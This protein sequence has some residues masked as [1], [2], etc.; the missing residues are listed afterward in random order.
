MRGTPSWCAVTKGNLSIDLFAAR[1]LGKW[2]NIESQAL[3]CDA[4]DNL[5]PSFCSSG[6]IPLFTLTQLGAECCSL[7]E[8]SLWFTIVSHAMVNLFKN[9]LSKPWRKIYELPSLLLEWAILAAA[10]LKGKGLHSK[11]LLRNQL[12]QRTLI[13]A[14]KI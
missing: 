3:L 13:A 9:Q 14:R 6:I 1:E 8:E 4:D 11:I 5:K 10:R 7:T 12:A 2:N